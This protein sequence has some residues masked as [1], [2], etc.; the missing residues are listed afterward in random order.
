MAQK[1][2]VHFL[3][4][5]LRLSLYRRDI[6]DKISPFLKYQYMPSGEIKSIW[7]AIIDFQSKS[8]GLPSF[9]V[10]SE[11]FKEDDKICVEIDRIQTCDLI[12][13]DTL[14]TQLQT[15]IKEAR[16][17]ITWD[18]VYELHESGERDKAIKLMAAESEEIAGFSL[19]K[20][21]GNFLQVFK[22]FAKVQLEK[23]TEAESGETD[24]S[25]LPFGILP[26][27]L[28]S[29]GGMDRKD[30][31]LWIMR[32][33]VGK[34]TVLKWQGMYACR[35]GYDVLHVQLEGSETEV[36]DKYTQLWAAST[37]SRVKR[38][39]IEDSEFERLI[40]IATNMVA[41]NRD[42]SIKSYE[43]FDEASMRDIRALV[44]QYIDEHGKAP[45][46]LL[47]DSLDLVHPGDGLHYGADTQSIKMKIQ[48]SAR[49]FKNICGEFDMRGVTVTQT[50]DVPFD[51]WNNPDKHLT[52]SN[53]QGDKNVANT[54]SF[55]FT[56][57]QTLLEE[58]NRTMRI[59]SDKVR[60]YTPGQTRIHPIATNFNLGRFIDQSRTLQIFSDVYGQK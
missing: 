16:F 48:N 11:I 10:L 49:K 19:F 40:G 47:L 1:L 29:E 30:T 15:F 59:F 25:K 22:D 12:P 44:I 17:Q 33:G 36:F 20:D 18:K 4:E 27:D 56:G 38:G 37:Y 8:G 7:K 57:N 24:M 34:S 53:S 39:E 6:F 14:L 31:V 32:S 9:G 41:L 21:N 60:Y 28:L 23:I 2:N 51:V 58:K 5:V 55:V 45:D 26:C 46:L 42:L 54:F 43:Q 3:Q 50:G 13:E 35:L 52:R